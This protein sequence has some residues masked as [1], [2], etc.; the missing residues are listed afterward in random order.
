MPEARL[1]RDDQAHRAGWTLNVFLSGVSTVIFRQEF[2]DGI[3]N[4]SITIAFRRWRR[5]SVKA[6]EVA[7]GRRPA[8]HP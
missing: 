4:G 2:L 6:E 1:S 7:D 3:R 5:P 8:P